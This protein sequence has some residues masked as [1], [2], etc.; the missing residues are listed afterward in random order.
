[1]DSEMSIVEKR[2]EQ[3]LSTKNIEF[4]STEHGAVYYCEEAAV[5]AGHAPEDGLKSMIFKTKEGKYVLVLNPGNKKIDTKEIAK[6]EKTKSLYLAAPDEVEKVAGI[7]IG[8]VPPFGHKTRLKTYLNKELLSREYLYFNP[9][10]HT[11]TMKIKSQ[12]LLK[13]LEKPIIF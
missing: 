10:S 9:G 4:E 2:I 7:Q 6:L 8:C 1:M 13:V 11:K 3:T 5:A 12:D